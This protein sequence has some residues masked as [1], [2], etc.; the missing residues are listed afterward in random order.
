MANLLS[1]L[2]AIVAGVG[3]IVGLY[4]LLYKAV[5]QLPAR[6]E[7]RLK[8]Y[9]FI[10]PPLALLGVFLLWP[11]VRTIWLSFF[12]AGA[13][14]FVGL[15]NYVRLFTED[16]YQESILNTLLWVIIVPTLSVG[17]GLLVAVLSDRLKETMEKVTKSVIFMPMAIALVAAGTTFMFIYAWAVPGTDQYGLVNAIWT[18]LGG[19][20][21]RW[22]A[23]DTG[24]LNTIL[25][26]LILVWMQ[27][28][29]AM[30]LLS[31]AI[32]NVP[33]ETLEAARID[34]ATE[35]QIFFQVVVPQIATTIM[36][37]FTTIMIFV[38]KTFDVV[39]VTT[40]GREGTD[41]LPVTFF[42]ELVQTRDQG[43]AA[44]V[45]VVILIATTPVMVYNVRRYR[46]QEAMS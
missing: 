30:V 20:P 26:T 16:R 18:G 38:L 17:L 37:V 41:F 34:G 5:E 21:Q 3:G 32:K 23:I 12:D 7:E 10:G 6:W 28:G 15:D 45:I 42:R 43:M 22:L 40:G 9:V 19:Q 8:P 2:L 4:W 31:A 24:R 44:A 13:N 36:V 35:V 29:F 25:L 11:G 14:A 27:A 39:W 46:Q 1:G 33:E